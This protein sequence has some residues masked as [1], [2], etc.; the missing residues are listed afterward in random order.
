MSVRSFPEVPWG[1]LSSPSHQSG[2]SGGRLVC[3]ETVGPAAL[4]GR[5]ARSLSCVPADPHRASELGP[6]LPASCRQGLCF[7]GFSEA[8]GAQPLRWLACLLCS[9]GC[10]VGCGGSSGVWGPRQQPA[11]TGCGVV[12]QFS[13]NIC[14]S[15]G[16]SSSKIF[17]DQRVRRER[18]CRALL[19]VERGHHTQTLP[20]GGDTTPCV[21]GLPG[22]RPF[23][24]PSESGGE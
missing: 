6:V 23:F 19:A 7:S 21:T 15:R 22:T 3:S 10:S 24:H 11:D 1:S 2:V 20:L 4:A 18:I 8:A 13:Q 9:P 16:Q 5:Q 14:A 17:P 12:G